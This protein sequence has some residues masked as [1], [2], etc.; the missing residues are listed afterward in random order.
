MEDR[1]DITRVVCIKQ[2]ETLNPGGHYD[3]KGRGNLSFNAD[4]N[5]DG[6]EGPGYC[7]EDPRIS[8]VNRN[9]YGTTKPIW[10]YFTEKEMS[11]YFITEEEDYKVE[12]RDRKIREIGIE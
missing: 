6:R 10:Y 7:I 11:E 4:P 3:I 12:Q 5:V 2:Y 9:S 1:W 8:L